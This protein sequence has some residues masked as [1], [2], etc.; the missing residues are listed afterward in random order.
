MSRSRVVLAFLLLTGCVSQGTFDALQ[1]DFDK[2]KATLQERE[3]TLQQRES[4]NTG[5]KATLEKERATV[6]DLNAQ[7]KKLE[8]ELKAT[9][10]QKE[11][12]E[13]E[14]SA[15][16]KDTSRLQSSI[17][18]M[19][20]AL[21]DLAKRKAEAEARIN[22]FKSLIGRFKSLIDAGK[23]KVKMVDGRMVVA[24][25]SDV[26][27][28]SG[29]A[30]LSKDGKAALAEVARLLAEIPDRKFQVEGHTDNVPISTA[31][32]PSNW[33]LAMARA[34][35]VVKTMSDAG[36]PADRISAASYGDSK[37]AQ[38]NDTVEGKAANRRIEIVV[39]PDLSSLP[40]FEELNRVAEH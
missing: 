23:L 31:Q 40:G 3:A 22:E 8:G 29:S 38:A 14:K 20:L 1:A 12:L 6:E 32:Y 25:A 19:R 16:V 5:L 39:V 30:S 9:T 36:M 2:T 17:E 27:F 4:E 35:S 34:L 13:T 33:E 18:E 37:P 15:M 26:L 24:L 10:A 7:M 28:A 11:A 21:A